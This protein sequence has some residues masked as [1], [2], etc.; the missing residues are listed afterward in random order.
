MSARARMAAR[1]SG[2]ARSTASSSV[3]ASFE[4]PQLHERAA[5]RHC[6]EMYPGCRARP[7]RHTFTAS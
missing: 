3:A 1:L 2:A 5:E 7:S 6:A 4:L